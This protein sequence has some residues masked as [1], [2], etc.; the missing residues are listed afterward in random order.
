MYT[1]LKILSGEP[2]KVMFNTQVA[3]LPLL[4]SLRGLDEAQ[5]AA[6][7]YR[8]GIRISTDLLQNFFDVSVAEYLLNSDCTMG[9]LILNELKEKYHCRF[10]GSVVGSGNDSGSSA[11]SSMHSWWSTTRSSESGCSSL[12]KVSSVVSCLIEDLRC[13]L[14][15][16]DQQE[17]RLNG[18]RYETVYPFVFLLN[19][20]VKFTII[21]KGHR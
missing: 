7:S 3:L 10:R 1:L 13:L 9:M 11:G 20:T 16:S 12:G 21:V 5:S 19:I 18:I 6:G 17:Q 8:D 4:A 2:L 15:I 14:V